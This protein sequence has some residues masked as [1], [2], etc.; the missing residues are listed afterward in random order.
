MTRW[1]TEAIRKAAGP[2]WEIWF[3]PD[4]DQPLKLAKPGEHGLVDDL[5][6]IHGTREGY[7]AMRRAQRAWQKTEGGYVV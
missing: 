7:P 2:D 5:G 3:D 6:Q 4:T 1:R